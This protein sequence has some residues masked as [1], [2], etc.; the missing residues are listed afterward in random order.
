[1]PLKWPVLMGL[2]LSQLYPARTSARVVIS[3]PMTLG[4]T[5]RILK[6]VGVVPML[7]S[8]TSIQTLK[9]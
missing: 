7:T 1:M 6:F 4:W 3:F 5:L 9:V 2:Q 8:T